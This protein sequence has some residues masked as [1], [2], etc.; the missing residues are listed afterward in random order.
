[1]RDAELAQEMRHPHQ[2]NNALGLRGVWVSIYSYMNEPW[3]SCTNLHILVFALADMMP[4]NISMIC[5]KHEAKKYKAVLSPEKDCMIADSS[6]SFGTPFTTF[7][8]RLSRSAQADVSRSF[9]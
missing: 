2:E 5:L 4:H 8:L 9:T 3:P 7:T 6:L 1:M